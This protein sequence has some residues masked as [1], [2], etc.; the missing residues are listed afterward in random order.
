MFVTIKTYYW[1]IGLHWHD[2]VSRYSNINAIR[3]LSN[4]GVKALNVETDL[5]SVMVVPSAAV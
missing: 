3:M 1:I 5:S 2:C 4:N